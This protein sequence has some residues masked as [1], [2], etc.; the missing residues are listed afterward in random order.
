LVARVSGVQRYRWNIVLDLLGGEGQTAARLYGD[1]RRSFGRN[2]LVTLKLKAGAGTEPTFPQTLFRLGGL[3]SVRGF[4]YGT[5]RSPA[6]WATQLDFSPFA[7]RVRP[8]LFIDAGQG[9]RLADLFSSPALVGGGAGIALFRGLVRL[10]FSRP[11]SPK[12]VRK[13]RFDLVLQG[14]R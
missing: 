8:V 5:L 1:V 10:D 13:V 14:L 4:E 6:F 9:A 2:R 3:N 11:I 7:G 12:G